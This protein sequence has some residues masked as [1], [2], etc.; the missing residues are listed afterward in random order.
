ML[1]KY[2]WLLFAKPIMK[3]PALRNSKNSGIWYFPFN[4]ICYFFKTYIFFEGAENH[5][6]FA[7]RKTQEQ[8][9]TQQ[10]ASPQ[11][12][13]YARGGSHGAGIGGGQDA[14]GAIVAIHGG[15]VRAFGGVDAAG[16]GS[17]ERFT[18]SSSVTH[19]GELTV[20]GGDVF[21]DGTGWGAGIGGGEDA[22]GA[23]VVITGGKVV[24]WAGE[25]AGKKNGSAIG[26]EDGDGRRGSLKLGDNM[27][28]HA[29]QHPS[30]A[31]NNLFPFATRVPACF[32]R[33]YACIEVG[34][35][36]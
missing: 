29:G 3:K 4:D 12:S 36:K 21:A 10:R 6:N 7:T 23:K 13:V 11:P 18:S 8:A 34:A 32:F 17:G 1:E 24:A 33:P 31:Q 26:S 20:T 25:D 14:S 15:T 2:E 16:I 30:D 35:S 9:A 5:H 19:G 22:M 28:V 27:R